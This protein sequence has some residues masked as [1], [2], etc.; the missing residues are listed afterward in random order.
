[1]S[2]KAAGIHVSAVTVYI[3]QT[4]TQVPIVQHVIVV[5]SLDSGKINPVWG[6]CITRKTLGMFPAGIK[7]EH[8]APQPPPLPFTDIKLNHHINI[9]VIFAYKLYLAS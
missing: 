9:M 6:F 8:S 4:G 7:Q 5:L 2:S 1:M 3:R